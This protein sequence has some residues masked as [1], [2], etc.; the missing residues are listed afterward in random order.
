M[1]IT[2]LAGEFGVTREE[3]EFACRLASAIGAPLL[4]GTTA[5]LS[6]DREYVVGQLEKYNLRLAIENEVEFT[7]QE[8]LQQIGDGDRGRIGTAVDTGWWATHNYDVVKAIHELREFILHV[9][10]KDVLPGEEHINCG[11]GKGCVPIADCVHALS[12]IGYIGVVSIE[13]HSLDHDPLGEIVEARC[14]LENRV[15]E[16][17]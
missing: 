4:S 3:F 15:N 9:H 14:M 6:T 11:Y 17:G 5:L 1:E 16:L 8:I 12:E 10:L 13:N 7:P 2:S